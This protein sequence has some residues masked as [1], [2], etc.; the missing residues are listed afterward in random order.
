MS[1]PKPTSQIAWSNLPCPV[2]RLNFDNLRGIDVN[3][4]DVDNC[5]EAYAKWCQWASSYSPPGGLDVWVQIGHWSEDLTEWCESEGRFE[6]HY[7]DGAI[8]M[9]R[10][11]WKTLNDAWIE[12]QSA[13]LTHNPFAELL[14]RLK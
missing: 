2:D 8:F 12:E 4:C 3:Y 1:I 6:F 11:E 5:D 13:H 10:D 9:R 7:V 14:K